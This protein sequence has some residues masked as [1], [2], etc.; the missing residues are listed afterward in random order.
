MRHQTEVAD[1]DE[2]WWQYMEQEPAQEFI[3]WQG[4]QSLF[5]FVSRV[6]PAEADLSLSQFDQ[7]VIGNGDAVR[8]VAQIFKNVFWTPKWSFG[9]NDPLMATALTQEDRKSPRCGQLVQ[10]SGKMQLASGQSRPERVQELA[11]KGFGHRLDRKEKVIARPDPA[12][13]V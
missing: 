13:A 5:V 10:L 1:A 8:V 11:A 12:G 6:A 2:S 4:H 7:P 9:I 3:D